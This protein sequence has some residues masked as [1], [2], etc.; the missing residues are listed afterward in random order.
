VSVFAHGLSARQD[1]PIPLGFAVTG[2]GLAVLVSFVAT[3]V[4]W[5]RPRLRGDV[6]GRPL[7]A[8]VQRLLDARATR[9]AL[10]ALGLA[11]TAFFV[12]AAAYGAPDPLVN[13]APGIVY[14]FFWVGLVPLSLL[15]GPVWKLLNPLRTVHLFMAR[16][17][18]L[19]RSSPGTSS[20]WWRRTTGPPGSSPA[21]RRSRARCRCWCSWSAT[22]SA[23]C[24]C[25]SPREAGAPHT[26]AL[27]RSAGAGTALR[28]SASTTSEVST[29]VTSASHGAAVTNSCSSAL[30]AIVTSTRSWCSPVT[31]AA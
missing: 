22:P 29:A 5:K 26:G 23:G 17:A 30:P 10:R 14:V 4:L 2:A 19:P 8:G 6:A 25:S 20:A 24:R 12:A 28:L 13:P 18:G 1:L 9:W 27:A 15:F 7:P 3:A 11:G 21:G 31:A 16:V